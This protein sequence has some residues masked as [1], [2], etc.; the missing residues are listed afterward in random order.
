MFSRSRS[1]VCHCNALPRVPMAA[2]TEI[3]LGEAGKGHP[4][5]QSACCQQPS[6]ARSAVLAVKS[7]GSS[8]KVPESLASCNATG[9]APHLW[10]VLITLFSPTMSN[11]SL[12]K[13]SAE[14]HLPSSPA[15]MMVFTE[16]WSGLTADCCRSRNTAC[17]CLQLAHLA[18]NAALTTPSS[19]F[20]RKLAMPACWQ[21][22][23][24]FDIIESDNCHRL[25]RAIVDTT[26]FKLTS[27]TGTRLVLI[28]LRVATARRHAEFREQ[29]K[30]LNMTWSGRMAQTCDRGKLLGIT[31]GQLGSTGLQI[32]AC[33]LRITLHTCCHEL[34]VEIAAL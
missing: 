30:W 34:K 7:S 21:G 8:R 32:E 13:R 10:I 5:K 20:S 23:F 28:L 12:N 18:F 4:R 6:Q 2:F 3:R 1:A 29:M 11:L 25:P 33:M 15:C 22:R 24:D 9:H 14:V 17:T 16:T 27:S 19:G 26:D 31:G